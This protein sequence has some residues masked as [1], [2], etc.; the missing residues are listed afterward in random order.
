MME[1]NKVRK[2]A[3]KAATG[4]LKTPKE[5]R[6]HIW[7]KKD[8]EGLI[9]D[10]SLYT[11]LVR[12]FPPIPEIEVN[13]VEIVELNDTSRTTRHEE[14]LSVVSLPALEVRF[15]DSEYP[16]VQCIVFV[17]GRENIN[18]FLQVFINKFE[19]LYPFEKA[20]EDATKL[21]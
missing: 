7:K 10:S 17:E 1:M 13:E 15:R 5:T 20:M 21:E 4:F 3:E 16:D 14:S 18:T 9:Y 2:I 8:S 12:R 6:W 11:A 19:E